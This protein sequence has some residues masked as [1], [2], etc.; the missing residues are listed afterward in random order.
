MGMALV[1]TLYAIVTFLSIYL[2]KLPTYMVDRR[3]MNAYEGRMAS[4]LVFACLPLLALGAQPLGAYSAWAPAILIGIACAGHQAWSANIYSCVSDMFP[5]SCVGTLTGI[6][7][8]AAGLGSFCVNYFA[9][10]FFTYAEKRGEAFAF[11][12]YTGK[13]AG[14]G[15]VFCYCAVAYLLGWVCMKT[16]VPRYRRVEL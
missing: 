13:S 6:A 12:G 10:W 7:Q 2:C 1:V 5:K 11:L 4:M 16:L 8:C 9:G 14:Y 15:V 3:G